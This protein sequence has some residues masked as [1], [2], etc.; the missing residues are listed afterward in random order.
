MTGDTPPESPTAGEGPPPEP[1][2]AAGTSATGFPRERPLL[3]KPAIEGRTSIAAP[4]LAGFSLAMVGVIASGPAHFRWPGATLAA[5]MIPIFCLLYVARVGSR[6]LGIT[7]ADTGSYGAYDVLARRTS[8]LFG[9]GICALWACIA[10][11][12]APPLSGGQETVFRWV[13]FAL[14]IAAGTV[15]AWWTFRLRAR[16]KKVW[17]RPEA[18][19]FIPTEQM[20]L[21]EQTSYWATE[22][23]LP[24]EPGR[25][26]TQR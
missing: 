12:A 14:A 15:E 6:A 7:V 1:Q 17:F 22:I 20:E 13:A 9:I 4:V 11:T 2:A 16:P 24:P 3:D 18:G 8:L 5:L 23:N 19:R 25:T 21:T 26:E 10:M